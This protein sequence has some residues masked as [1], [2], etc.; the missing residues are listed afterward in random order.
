VGV[1]LADLSFALVIYAA[2]RRSGGNQLWV[3][4]LRARW[5][6][7]V[8]MVSYSLYLFH[9][10]LLVVSHDLVGK[11][12][13]PRRVDALGVDLLGLVL[14]FAVAYGL[15]YGMESRILRWKDRKVPSPA[16]A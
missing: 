10:P 11:L 16:H 4:L 3:R 7:S 6:R 5:L 1:L 9:F 2:I 12:H 13:L 14:S 15:W 8:G